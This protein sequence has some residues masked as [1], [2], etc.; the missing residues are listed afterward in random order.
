MIVITLAAGSAAGLVAEP[1]LISMLL[2]RSVTQQIVNQKDYSK[3]KK[4]VNQMLEND[5]LKQTVQAF[6]IEG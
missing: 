5:E 1:V 4:L 2:I 3:F 6:F